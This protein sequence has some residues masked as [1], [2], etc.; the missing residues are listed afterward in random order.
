[1]LCLCGFLVMTA[2]LQ[3]VEESLLGLQRVEG[4]DCLSLC[5]LPLANVGGILWYGLTPHF[6]GSA[7][8]RTCRS[9]GTQ[10]REEFLLYFNMAASQKAET[11]MSACFFVRTV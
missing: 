7:R 11:A 6:I 4:F 5:R 2:E 3:H 8:I 1:M 9:D 10:Q